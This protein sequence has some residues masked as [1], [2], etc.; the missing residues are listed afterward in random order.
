MIHPRRLCAVTAIAIASLSLARTAPADTILY[1]STGDSNAD[2]GG[3]LYAIDVTTQTVTLI[4]NTGFDRLSG[5]AFNNSGSLFGVAGGGAHPGTLITINPNTAAASTVGMIGGGLAVDALRFDAQN[6]LYGGAYDSS[7]LNGLLV[8][9]DPMNGNLLSQVILS[10]SGV[11][12]TPGL[13]F[14]PDGV[15]YGSRGNSAGHTEDLDVINPI[16]G[17]LTPI[18]VATNSITDIA[19]G[20]DGLLYG[21]SS[22]GNLYSIDQ[23]TGVETVLFDTGVR[24][25]GLAAASQ[26]VPEG[27]T[28]LLFALGLIYLIGFYCLVMPNNRAEQDGSQ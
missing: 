18:G 19:F 13:A 12:F 11:A 6:R 25:S 2:G 26:S 4:G 24:L 17:Q 3:R 5:I 9:I 1:G 8:T 7:I 28:M 27:S 14:S 22:N 20:Q 16:T 23:T 10:G 15:L 21:V